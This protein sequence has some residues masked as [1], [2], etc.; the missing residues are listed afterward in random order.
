MPD[1][2]SS[3]TSVTTRQADTRDHSVSAPVSAPVSAVASAPVSEAGDAAG[4]AAAVP[5][6]DGAVTCEQP[7]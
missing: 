6:A 3:N 2:N 5:D 1:R 4:G 7:F